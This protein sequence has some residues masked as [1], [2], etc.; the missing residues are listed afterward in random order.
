[1]SSRIST[2]FDSGLPLPIAAYGNRLTLAN[3]K[4]FTNLITKFFRLRVP[5]DTQ[6]VLSAKT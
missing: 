5:T 3:Q 1:M 4:L 6:A 2:P